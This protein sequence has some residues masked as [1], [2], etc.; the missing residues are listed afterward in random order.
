MIAL[1]STTCIYPV[2]LIPLPRPKQGLQ[3]TGGQMRG[4][5]CYCM[6][7]KLTAGICSKRV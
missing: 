1:I 5:H 2:F 4:S 6:G 7:G 3:A